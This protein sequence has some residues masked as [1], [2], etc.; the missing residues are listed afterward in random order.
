[1]SKG[2]EGKVVV[3]T[4]ASSGL[5]E[6]TA[7]HLARLG[8]AVV[9]GA[10]REER[11]NAIVEEIKAEGG[12]ATAQ[13]VDVTRRED[14]AALVQH[15]VSTFGRVDVMINNAGLMAISP[16]AE[17][18]VDEWD[19]MIDINIKGVM[20]GIAAALPLFEQQG[21]GHFIN[22]SSVAGIKVFS[23]GGSVYSGTKYAVRAI[24][25]GLRHEV[26]SSIRTTTIEPGAVDSELKHGSTHVTSAQAVAEFY[27]QA[28][29][30]ESVARAIAFAIEQPADVDINEI[31][32]RPTSQD[33]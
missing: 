17:L 27:K 3:I 32:L 33:F 14:L 1:M 28:I 7:R 2:I 6:S 18:R 23:P 4:G 13:V 31:V 16:I 22:I 12:K 25:E 9:L 24:S 26:G 29:P 11:L 10:R 30:A 21:A 8:A 5:G 20:Y 15:A 19:R